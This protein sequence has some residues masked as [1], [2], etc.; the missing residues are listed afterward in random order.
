MRSF[1]TIAVAL[2]ALI[3]WNSSDTLVAPEP[4][5]ATTAA[6]KGGGAYRSPA[7]ACRGP[8]RIRGPERIP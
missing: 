5:L 8:G 7:S 3:G 4:Q 2:G 1:A 6:A